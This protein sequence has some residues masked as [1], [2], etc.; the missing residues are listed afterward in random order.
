MCRHAAAA[1]S[2]LVSAPPLSSHHCSSY[3]TPCTTTVRT[4]HPL[5]W[6]S[7]SWD[8]VGWDVHC[9]CAVCVRVCPSHVVARASLPHWSCVRPC[10]CTYH[11]NALG[12][13]WTACYVRDTGVHKP[14]RVL[15]NS[16]HPWQPQP[17]A[18]ATQEGA[19]RELSGPL[20]RASPGNATGKA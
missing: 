13:D 14:G 3:H 5:V 17:E 6:G 18:G 9:L 15:V 1:L 16:R 8:V 19:D 2:T 10:C 4:R 7:Q 11:K 20:L 12:L